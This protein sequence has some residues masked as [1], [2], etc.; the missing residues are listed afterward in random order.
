MTTYRVDYAHDDQPDNPFVFHRLS[1]AK[2]FAKAAKASARRNIGM[3]YV[4][5]T[6]ANGKDLGQRVYTYGV[7]THTDGDF[8]AA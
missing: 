7:F 6:D 2:A 1:R 4:I 5:A 8:P 3:A